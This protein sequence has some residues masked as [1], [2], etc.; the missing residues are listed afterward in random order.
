MIASMPLQ[1][2]TG[3]ITT[4]LKL[5]LSMDFAT[6]STRADE[7]NIPVFMA[8]MPIPSPTVAI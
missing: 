5:Y 1:T 2:I 7:P 6:N 3:S 4:F 8:L